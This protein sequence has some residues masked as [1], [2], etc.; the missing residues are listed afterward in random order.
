MTEAEP[1]VR[2]TQQP[3]RPTTERLAE[4]GGFR[5]SSVPTAEI[6][7]LEADLVP[8]AESVR[9]LVD[10]TIRTTVDPDELRRARAEIDAITARLRAAQLPGAAGVHFNHEGRSWQWGNAAVGV[11]NAAAPAMTVQHGPGGLAYADV[12]LGAAHEGPPGKVHGGIAALLLDHVMGVTASRSTRPMMTGTLTLRYRRATPLG[13]VRV[14]G[15]ID[16]QTGDKAVVIA[17]ILDADGVTVEAE[18][19]FVV[20]RWARGHYGSES[21]N[22]SESSNG[23]ESA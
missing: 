21:N 1:G 19:I 18:G 13:P 3:D 17:Q 11:R 7:R 4:L 8:L 2:A 5:L 6:D 22:G 14:E 12:V 20:P 9:E 10:A 16:R 15:R 23:S